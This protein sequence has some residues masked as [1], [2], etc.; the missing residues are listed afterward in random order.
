MA[1]VKLSQASY[2]EVLSDIEELRLQADT[3][4]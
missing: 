3:Y 1:E 4:F 2:D